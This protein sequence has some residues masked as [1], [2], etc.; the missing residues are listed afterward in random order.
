MQ[1]TNGQDF[2]SAI[3]FNIGTGAPVGGTLPIEFFI[4]KKKAKKLASSGEPVFEDLEYCKI[5]VPG[6]PISILEK[7]VDDKVKSEFGMQYQAWVVNKS[8]KMPGI[9][10]EE[11]PMVQGDE[12]SELKTRGFHTVESIA[13]TGEQQVMILGQW[14]L[15]LREKAIAYLAAIKDSAALAKQSEQYAMAKA[16]NAALRLELEELKAAVKEIQK[17]KKGGLKIDG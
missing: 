17:N 6:A 14:G 12:I 2:T 3:G 10:V 5:Y 16:E 7:Q 13:G 15:Q 11:W 4:K 1:P 9:P 8:Q